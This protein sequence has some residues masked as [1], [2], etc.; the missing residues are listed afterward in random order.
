M[1]TL[2]QRLRFTVPIALV[3]LLSLT[4]FG[5]QSMS[6]TG[7]GAV[8]G[9]GAGAVVGGVIGKATGKKQG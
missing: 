7:Q 8:V 5:C 1:Q 2:T 9:A 6:K 3:A 4:F